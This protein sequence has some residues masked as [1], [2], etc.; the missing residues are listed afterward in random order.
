MDILSK[1]KEGFSL[2]LGVVPIWL[3]E[4]GWQDIWRPATR[5]SNRGILDDRYSI[6]IK[7]VGFLI[8]AVLFAE[9]TIGGVELQRNCIYNKQ[10]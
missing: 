7:L 4:Q 8:L 5:K 2:D 9:N 3:T 1:V 10:S 6:R